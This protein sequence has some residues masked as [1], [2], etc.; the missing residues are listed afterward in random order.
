MKRKLHYEHFVYQPLINNKQDAK[1]NRNIK[2]GTSEMIQTDLQYVRLRSM[3]YV[4]LVCVFELGCPI[5]LFDPNM[6]R[7]KLN[8]DEI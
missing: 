4:G 3:D 8:L 2:M 6:Y 5:T 7:P 1:S